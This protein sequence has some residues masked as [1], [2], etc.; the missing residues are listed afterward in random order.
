V[1][2]LSTEHAAVVAGVTVTA[3]GAREVAGAIRRSPT[4]SEE[5]ER[6][7]MREWLRLLRDAP[8]KS[9]AVFQADV[10][11]FERVLTEY[12]EEAGR[13]KDEALKAAL[14]R[15]KG[16]LRTL[17]DFGTAPRLE[18]WIEEAIACTAIPDPGFS[19][20]PDSWWRR[21]RQH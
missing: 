14:I 18:D 10:T 11:E 20:T 5:A 3:A 9:E 1:A 8:P 12:I 2:G 19:L 7:G 6:E 16:A 4:T 13:Q 17:R 15:V 21:G